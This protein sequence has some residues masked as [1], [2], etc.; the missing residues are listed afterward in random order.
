[1]SRALSETT[2][3]REVLERRLSTLRT[4]FARAVEACES[5][6]GLV[7][8][9]R[10]AAARTANGAVAK[11]LGQLIEDFREDRISPTSPVSPRD[12]E[13]PLL[14]ALAAREIEPATIAFPAPATPP[15][16][17]PAVAAAPKKRKRVGRLAEVE[18]E[19]PTGLQPPPKSAFEPKLW[20]ESGVIY[21]QPRKG[22]EVAFWFDGESDFTLIRIHYP[23]EWLPR[24]YVRVL[25]THSS[26]LKL[27]K[28]PREWAELRATDDVERREYY[29]SESWVKS[30]EERLPL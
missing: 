3:F 20:G 29:G 14:D 1:M 10:L 13:Y 19:R 11:I 5:L 25:I 2:L 17:L 16:S 26:M 30:L 12:E 27:G 15:P 18:A 4:T 8:P 6:D 21:V 28:T 22:V 23:E 9:E 7:M 24:E